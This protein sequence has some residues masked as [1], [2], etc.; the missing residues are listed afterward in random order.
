MAVFKEAC[1]VLGMP[2]DPAKKD[3]P[4]RVITF[5]GIELDTRSMVVRLPEKRLKALKRMVGEGGGVKC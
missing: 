2:L 5:L 1:E 3:G 4:A